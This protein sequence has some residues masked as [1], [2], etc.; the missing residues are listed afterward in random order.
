MFFFGVFGVGDKMRELSAAEL[1]CPACGRSA[2]FHI[3]KQFSYFHFFFIPLLRWGGRF[4]ATCPLCASAFEVNP[5][6]G[7][8]AEKDGTPIRASDLFLLR[9]NAVG[10]CPGCGAHNPPGSAYC[11]RCG[12]SL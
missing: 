11:N 3:S 4:F 12:R 8:N 1:P 6:A 10:L 9:N 7:K 2:Q 5:E